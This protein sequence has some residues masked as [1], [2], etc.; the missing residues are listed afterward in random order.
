MKLFWRWATHPRNLPYLR[1][2]YEAHFIALQKPRVYARHLS[3]A[4]FEWTTLI[5][6]HLPPSVASKATA[7]LRAAV[8][9]GLMIE[10]L[11]S[12][13]LRRTTRALDQF[14]EMLRRKAGI[15]QEPPR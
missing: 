8:F 11:A 9:D 7:T 6:A 12:G 2:M 14:I 15:E 1:L 13:D 10:L 4:S 5:E 3:R